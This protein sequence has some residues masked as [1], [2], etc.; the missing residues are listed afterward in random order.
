MKMLRK[1][2]QDLISI[3]EKIHTALVHGETLNE[4][5]KDFIQI[6]AGQLMASASRTERFSKP[7]LRHNGAG[8]QEGS[9]ELS[10]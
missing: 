3:Y 8:L 1:E 5:E 6:C 10:K 2:V 4:D 7:E 9:V